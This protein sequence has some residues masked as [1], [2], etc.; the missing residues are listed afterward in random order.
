M[1][2]LLEGGAIRSERSIVAGLEF[3][4]VRSF[5]DT[6]ARVRQHLSPVFVLL[7]RML[8]FAI[9]RAEHCN[10]DTQQQCDAQPDIELS[11]C[12]WRHPCR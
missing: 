11:W 12:H 2:G 4:D 5:L 7:R 1:L 9:V 10:T 8:Q 3:V 6:R